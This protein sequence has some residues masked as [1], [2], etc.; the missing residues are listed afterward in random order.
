MSTRQLVSLVDKNISHMVNA[1]LLYVL[2]LGTKYEIFKVL[3]KRPS[4]LDL[5][6]NIDVPNK[7]LLSQFIN[8][9]IELG[10][11]EE[12]PTN[13]M[14]NGFSYTLKV[15]SEDYK[16][17]LSDG[18]MMLEEI[19]RMVD[20]AL[21]TPDHPHVL[22]DFDK[23]AD[24][25]DMRMRTRFASGYREM[26]VKLGEIKND[27]SVID[28][29]CGSVSPIEFGKY[30]A[31]NGYYLGID[32]SPALIEIAKSRIESAGYDWANV[33]EMDAHLIKPKNTYNVAV[34]SFVLEYLNNPTRVL[35][36]VTESLKSGGKLIIVEPFRENFPYIEALEFF[37]RLNKDF[38]KFPSAEDIKNILQEKGFDLSFEQHG[39]SILVIKKL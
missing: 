9:L 25:W 18:I 14:L 31:P 16:L 30:L 13:L 6:N 22:M 17:L 28:I 11:V 12:T 38:V 15:P 21:I 1:A 8:T 36:R 37:E 24:F 29:G 4:T 19:Y 27:A 26:I 33:K 5:L 10:I 35:E 7:R 20:F 39:K 2:Q 32:Y 23:D 34:I 3:S